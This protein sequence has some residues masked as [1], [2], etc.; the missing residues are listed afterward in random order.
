MAEMI[1]DCPFCGGKAEIDFTEYDEK[2][3]TGND[4]TA[5]VECINCH[6]KIFDYWEFAIEKWNRRCNNG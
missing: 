2:T 6:A 4:G 3:D 5:W 1:K